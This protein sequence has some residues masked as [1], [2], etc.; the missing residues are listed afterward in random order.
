MIWAIALSLE[1][2]LQLLDA[3]PQADEKVV[4]RELAAGFPRHISDVVSAGWRRKA[5]S[6]PFFISLPGTLLGSGVS[7]QGAFTLVIPLKVRRF[8]AGLPL[9]PEC[10]LITSTLVACDKLPPRSSHKIQ[11]AV[12]SALTSC[13]IQQTGFAN[14]PRAGPGL[15]GAGQI[16]SVAPGFSPARAALKGRATFELGQHRLAPSATRRCTSLTD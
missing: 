11:I 10:K 1:D 16:L 2:F 7:T 3:F 4:R 15:A 13:T 14:N 5:A 9:A 6:T 12:L 8:D